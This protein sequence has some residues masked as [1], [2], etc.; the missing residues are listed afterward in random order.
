[1]FCVGVVRFSMVCMSLVWVVFCYGFGCWM[2]VEF[3]YGFSL[4]MGLEGP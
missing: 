2:V 3:V 4:C 1:M